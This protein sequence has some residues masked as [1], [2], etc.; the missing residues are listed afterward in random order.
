MSSFLLQFDRVLGALLFL[1]SYRS[2]DKYLWKL[3]L[4]VIFHNSSLFCRM[5]NLN[6]KIR[7]SS[8]ISFD[9][10]IHLVF[11]ANYL[12]KLYIVATIQQSANMWICK[13]LP[14]QIHSRFLKD[15]IYSRFHI[16][17]LF[18]RFVL[19]LTW[20]RQYELGRVMFGTVQEEK[21]SEKRN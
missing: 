9:L 16:K 4:L 5:F 18:V 12:W 11:S 20:T 1:V 6:L 2:S 3:L 17:S 8:F 10:Q 15:S 13:I 21:L 7:H 14:S 19:T